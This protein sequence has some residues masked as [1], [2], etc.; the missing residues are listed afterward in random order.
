[1]QLLD[2]QGQETA[3]QPEVSPE[4]VAHLSQNQLAAL[5]A[6]AVHSSPHA[7]VHI[8]CTVT[9][10]SQI[11]HGSVA[12]RGSTASGQPF[13]TA[14]DY[15]VLADGANSRLRCPAAACL[16]TSVVA[17]QEPHLYVLPPIWRAV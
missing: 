7:A 2:V 16:R 12:V 3:Q 6:Q 13:S 5:L 8:G 1:M 11:A 10:L 17:I 14:C 15:L 9:S 4:P